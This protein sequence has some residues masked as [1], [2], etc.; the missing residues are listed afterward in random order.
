MK[1]ESRSSPGGFLAAGAFH[2]RPST[3][4]LLLSCFLTGCAGYTLGPAK[5]EYLRNVR[6]LA[7]PVFRNNTLLPRLESLVATTVIRQLQQDGTFETTNDEDNADA[8]LIGTVEKVTRTP[9]RS[10]RGNVLLTQEFTLVVSLRYELRERGTRKMLDNG[11]V[12][13]QTNF[14]ISGDVQQDERQAIPLAVERAAVRLTS[15]LTE[16]F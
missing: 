10:V 4:I 13:G 14:F 8:I 11:R 3:F 15:Q 12:D 1:D 9:A 6:R 16:G 5:P 7:V 2:L